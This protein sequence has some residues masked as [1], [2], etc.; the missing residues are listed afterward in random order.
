MVSIVDELSQTEHANVNRRHKTQDRI[1]DVLGASKHAVEKARCVFLV[2][3]LGLGATFTHDAGQV[4]SGEEG[5]SFCVF[6][7][8]KR[9]QLL[10]ERD[11]FNGLVGL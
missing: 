1:D 7:R 4:F 5:L 9:Q 11:V 6:A 2:G 10:N 8:G 3:R